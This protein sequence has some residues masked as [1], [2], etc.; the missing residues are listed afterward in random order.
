ML[1]GGRKAVL[2]VVEVVSAQE[3]EGETDAFVLFPLEDEGRPAKAGIGRCL[4]FVKP[5]KD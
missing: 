5:E 4:L 1:A 3:E 2:A